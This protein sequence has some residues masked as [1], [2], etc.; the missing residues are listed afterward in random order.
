MTPWG[1][2]QIL[3]VTHRTVF[4]LPE[5]EIVCK[6][7]SSAV[8]QL[9]LPAGRLVKGLPRYFFISRVFAM[10]ALTTES[11]VRFA[12]YALLAAIRSIISSVVS[13]LG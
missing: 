4:I 7:I 12:S 13:T 8:K 5:G 10:V 1:T 9:W 3:R 6:H 11:A 2:T